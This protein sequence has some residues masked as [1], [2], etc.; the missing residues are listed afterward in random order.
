MQAKPLTENPA[1]VVEPTVTSCGG[2]MDHEQDDEQR[3]QQSRERRVFMFLALVLAPM[4]AV[5]LV[6]TYG[7]SIWIYQLIAGP[8]SS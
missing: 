1:M 4:L 5:A 6:G 7:L 2:G 3:R 8:P